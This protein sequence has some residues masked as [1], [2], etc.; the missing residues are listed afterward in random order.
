MFI[1]TRHDGVKKCCYTW[2]ERVDLAL[3]ETGDTIRYSRLM[4]AQ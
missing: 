2:F 4:C 1:L 3:E